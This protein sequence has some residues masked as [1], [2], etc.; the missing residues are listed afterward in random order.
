M[1]KGC[2]WDPYEFSGSGPWCYYKNCMDPSSDVCRAGE[3]RIDCG[4]YKIQQDECEERGCCWSPVANSPPWCFFKNSP[5]K[6]SDCCA[7]KVRPE[8]GR[9]FSPL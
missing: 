5:Q 9:P 2:C 7:D 8:C 6:Y 4:N 3:L 1:D